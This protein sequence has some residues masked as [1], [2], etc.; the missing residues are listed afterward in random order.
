VFPPRRPVFVGFQAGVIIGL[1]PDRT[2]LASQIWLAEQALVIG[3]NALI[4]PSRIE[5]RVGIA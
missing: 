5:C 3:R 4:D 2:R 1:T